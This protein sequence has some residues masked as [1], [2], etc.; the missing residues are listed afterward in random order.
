MK[1]HH[2]CLI[3]ILPFFLVNCS[4]NK[5]LVV[6]ENVGAKPD[7]AT[8]VP[9]TVSVSNAGTVVDS[10]SLFDVNCANVYPDGS[11]WT[12]TGVANSTLE[13]IKSTPTNS[14]VLCT[15]TLTSMVVTSPSGTY[16]QSGSNRLSFTFQA[17]ATYPYYSPVKSYLN[18]S[19]SFYL[20]GKVSK[21]TVSPLLYTVELNYSNELSAALAFGVNGP[22][23]VTGGSS[24]STIA[25]VTFTQ[26][27]ILAPVLSNLGVQKNKVNGLVDFT[28]FGNY[29]TQGSNY[30]DCKIFAKGGGTIP[31]YVG[32]T[33]S[34]PADLSQADSLFSYI[35][36]V[37]LG[38]SN[39]VFSCAGFILGASLEPPT[40][41]AVVSKWGRCSVV[42]P[43]SCVAS[44]DTTAAPSFYQYDWFV[45]FKNQSPNVSTLASYSYYNVPKQTAP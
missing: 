25:S 44:T 21:T 1:L 9:L 36:T 40:G 18:G 16:S 17:S 8:F 24:D 30:T 6:N 39:G 38:V 31:P 37:T 26:Q 13:I 29:G 41:G 19:N 43:S 10:S 28:M 27:G 15:I 3:T 2:A 32:A 45:I 35:P 12:Q 7:W 5:E 4:K 34:A 11:A 14:D 20:A 23:G 33:Y 42:G 22:G